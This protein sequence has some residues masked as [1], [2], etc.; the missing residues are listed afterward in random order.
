MSCLIQEG[1]VAR[2]Q[3]LLLD[4]LS[5][6]LAQGLSPLKRKDKGK[7]VQGSWSWQGRKG[8]GDVVSS[9]RVT[10]WGKEGVARARSDK[11]AG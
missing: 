10:L 6:A 11:G 8:G 5:R 2:T 9:P 7:A 1:I 3:L 4:T